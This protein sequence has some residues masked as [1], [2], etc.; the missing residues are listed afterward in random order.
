MHQLRAPPSRKR[1]SDHRSEPPWFALCR[2][3]ALAPGELP[4]VLYFVVVLDKTI[5]FQIDAQETHSVHGT[6]ALHAERTVC[7]CVFRNWAPG[8]REPGDVPMFPVMGGGLRGLA[9]RPIRAENDL[10]AR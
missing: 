9:P 3:R 4:P 2:H 7:D 10:N 6:P 5:I 8:A 1:G